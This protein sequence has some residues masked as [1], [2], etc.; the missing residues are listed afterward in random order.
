MNIHDLFP[1]SGG[2]MSPSAEFA[3]QVLDVIAKSGYVLAPAH[4]TAKMLAAGARAG[5]VSEDAA[6]QVYAAMLA[7]A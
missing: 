6:A 1:D 7:A 2:P 4:P 3:L 5:G